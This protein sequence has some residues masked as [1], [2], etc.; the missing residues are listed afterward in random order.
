[1]FQNRFARNIECFSQGRLCFSQPDKSNAELLLELLL[2]Y[3]PSM[4]FKIHYF[5]ISCSGFRRKFSL[6]LT[7]KLSKGEEEPCS[8]SNPRNMD[9]W[10][11]DKPKFVAL[12][13]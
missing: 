2:R 8:N 6:L 9:F 4:S 11:K 13:E 1:L 5:L 12:C 7:G 10:N 3:L